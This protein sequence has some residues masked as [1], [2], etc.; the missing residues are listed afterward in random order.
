MSLTITSPF[1]LLAASTTVVVI[2]TS[3]LLTHTNILLL[4]QS[5][6]Q[7]KQQ[8][9][10]SNEK[11]E[12]IYSS[13][14]EATITTT[15]VVDEE[16]EDKER[17]IILEEQFSRSKY[18]FGDSGQK[19][20]EKSF[21][22]VIGLGGV[23]SHV[24][25]MLSRSGV[26]RLRLIDYDQLTLSSLGRHALG[27]R[28]DVGDTKAEVLKRRILEYFPECY[29]EACVEMFE[30][31]SAERLLD[32][33]PDFVI[34]CIDDMETKIQVLIAAVERGLKIITSM[35]SGM[36]SDP[37]RLHIGQLYDV[38][39]DNMCYRLRNRFVKVVQA[40]GEF[41]VPLKFTQ[42]SNKKASQESY[43][44]KNAH[45]RSLVHDAMRHI[46]VVYSSELPQTELVTLTE[47]QQE[48]PGQFG[49]IAN[50]RLRLVPVLSTLPALFGMALASF[51]LTELGKKPIPA[52]FAL[53]FLSHN[54]VSSMLNHLSMHEAKLAKFWANEQDDGKPLK[55]TD[56]DMDLFDVQIVTVH[57]KRRC[58][59][60]SVKLGTGNGLVEL[61][62]WRFD[63]PLKMTNV[64]LVT[65]KYIDLL[66][67]LAQ[68]R[69]LPSPE[70]LGIDEFTFAEIER[71]L[72]DLVRAYPDT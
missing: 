2:A 37:T 26:G 8:K 28:Q 36:R 43:P 19:L 56:M 32:G 63:L 61:A 4:L 22:I 13:T 24:A 31:S 17:R 39:I 21:I 1:L 57:F 38:E 49:A 5:S 53:P 6:K 25:H 41:C 10:L 20:I 11:K 47:E 65:K 70:N 42:Q 34:D 64:V 30:E 40:R 18:F 15:T 9:S 27:T 72:H 48:D 54:T 46:N 33:N 60:T 7:Q 51:V 3:I 14:K 55:V 58:C 16:D 68:S 12:K 59:I 71:Y 66:Y 62:R 44:D 67:K 29:I 69:T 52:P 45:L 35:G 23:G 50:R